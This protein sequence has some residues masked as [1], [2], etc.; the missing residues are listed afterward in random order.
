M[1]PQRKQ[2]NRLAAC[3]ITCT[4][5]LTLTCGILGVFVTQ[6]NRDIWVRVNASVWWITR[7]DAGGGFAPGEE[8][9]AVFIGWHSDP[10]GSRWGCGPT[11]SIIFLPGI[12]IRN[13]EWHLPD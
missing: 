6:A 10:R 3:V 4:L 11:L 1:Q 13:C 12:A 5:L 2:R 9:D 7:W 8:K